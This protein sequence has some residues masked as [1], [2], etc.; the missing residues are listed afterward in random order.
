M[1]FNLK[2]NRTLLIYFYSSI[3]NGFWQNYLTIC[4]KRASDLP[5]SHP[6]GAMKLGSAH[7]KHS[8]EQMYLVPVAVFITGTYVAEHMEKH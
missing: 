4:L 5:V 2:I 1:K 3:P 8:W 7:T 6:Q